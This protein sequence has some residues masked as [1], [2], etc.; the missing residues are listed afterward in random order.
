MK[1]SKEKPLVSVV[2]TTYNRKELLKKT[3]DSIL[4]Q[5]FR[6]FELIVVDNFSDY[7]FLSHMKS[8]NDD[9]IIHFQNSNNGIIAVN[10]NYGINKARGK[11]I[12]F[13]DDDD[14]WKRNKLQIQLDHFTDDI[15]GVGSSSI[16]VGNISL[17]RRKNKIEKDLMLGFYDLLSKTKASLS[18][19]VVVNQGF[20]FD[21]NEKF[22][23]VEDF[24]YQLNITL[25]T[26]KKIK[27]I[28]E[29]LIYYR[30]HPE[31]KSGDEKIAENG[32]NVYHKYRHL[33]SE[34]QMRELYH[35][36]Y[37]GLGIK[38]IRNGSKDAKRYFVAAKKTSLGMDKVL[39]IMME[40]VAVMPPKLIK[41]AM[42]L[43]YNLLNSTHQKMP[44]LRQ[45][46]G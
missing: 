21:E 14:Y 9:R 25:Q 42:L 24:D 4:N 11:Y 33:I 34:D 35:K 1:T 15:I 27:I 3:I 8:F 12:A 30:I 16:K 2:V 26:K 23:S 46:K 36:K 32:F 22:T 40:F 37:F 18:S 7:G 20:M 41:I 28:S 17:H 43:Y 13:C 38:A 19:L 44:F 6:N 45:Q 31:N 5:T 10:R 39:S 29:P